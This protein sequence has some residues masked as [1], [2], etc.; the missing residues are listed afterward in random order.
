MHDGEDFLDYL[1]QSFSLLFSSQNNV[2]TFQNKQLEAA[3]CRSPMI[4]SEMS[5][6]PTPGEPVISDDRDYSY[7]IAVGQFR[8]G[9]VREG[10]LLVIYKTK[11]DDIDQN[12]EG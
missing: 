6:G 10:S 7:S 8:Q 11:D 12:D 1:F 5:L 9:K 2:I 3:G 4:Y